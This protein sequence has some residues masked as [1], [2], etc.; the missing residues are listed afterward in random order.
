MLF[1]RQKQDKSSDIEQQP[2]FDDHKYEVG[3][4]K[5]IGT[6]YNFDKVWSGV[7]DGCFGKQNR[8]TEGCSKLKRSEDMT[9]SGK[10]GL[11]I[12]TNA[13]PKWDRTGMLIILTKTRTVSVLSNIFFLLANWRISYLKGPN[14]ILP[15]LITFQNIIR[16]IQIIRCLGTSKTQLDIEKVERIC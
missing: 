14:Y 13:S 4:T 1:Q 3:V 8:S 15:E 10:N 6:S 11:N 16:T 7:P 5:P 12:R 2:S 9:S